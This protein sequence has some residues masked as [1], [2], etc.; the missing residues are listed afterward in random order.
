M[1]KQPRIDLDF[2]PS[3]RIVLAKIPRV[4][5][6]YRFVVE[7]DQRGRNKKLGDKCACTA[8][9]YVNNKPYCIRH[10]QSTA[11]DILIKDQVAQLID[12]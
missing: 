11:L 5:C 12:K 10:A 6:V 7:E 8:K 2:T 3:Y 1:S 9:I 4:A